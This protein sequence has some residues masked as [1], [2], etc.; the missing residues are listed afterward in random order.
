MKRT[1]RLAAAALLLA[2]AAILAP[3]LERANAA[4]ERVIHVTARRFAY[5]PSEIVV[6]QGEPVILELEALDREHGFR[7]PALHLRADLAPGQVA[8]VPL[9][10]SQKGRFP[11]ACDVFCGSGHEDMTGELVVE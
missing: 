8:R 3:T 2:G 6:K 9:V 7:L 11:F 1:G 5:E 10:A 4:P